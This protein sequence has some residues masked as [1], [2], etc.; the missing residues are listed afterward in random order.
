M[1][2]PFAEC[3]ERKKKAILSCVPQINPL[4]CQMDKQ[5]C[6]SNKCYFLM[7]LQINGNVNCQQNAAQTVNQ[8]SEF[9]FIPKVT[10]CQHSPTHSFS[11]SNPTTNCLHD[12]LF[13]LF[14][15]DNEAAIDI[16]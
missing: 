2:V 11:Y 9:V 4:F 3:E 12:F 10:T 15:F 14:G 7:N 13:I 6:K 8:Y 1:G 5:D 16:K